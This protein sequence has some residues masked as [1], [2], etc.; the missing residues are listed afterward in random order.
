MRCG[1]GSCGARRSRTPRVR[2]L[3]VRSS[4]GVSQS[5]AGGYGVQPQAVFSDFFFDLRRDFVRSDVDE[6]T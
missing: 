5:K 3:I 1:N 6:A 2:S 4:L